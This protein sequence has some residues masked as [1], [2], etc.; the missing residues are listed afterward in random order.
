MSLP[1]KSVVFVLVFCPPVTT[2]CAE[3][4]VTAE[5]ARTIAKEAYIYGTRWWTAT[6][7]CML[8]L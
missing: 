2:T 1:I 4:S 5:E 3:S 6:A 8:T 7:L